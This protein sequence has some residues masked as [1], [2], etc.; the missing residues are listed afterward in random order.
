MAG[1]IG[2]DLPF[3]RP[4]RVDVGD[5]LHDGRAAFLHRFVDRVDGHLDRIF[6]MVDELPDGVRRHVSD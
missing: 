3:R 1:E 5:G 2:V 4:G 6:T